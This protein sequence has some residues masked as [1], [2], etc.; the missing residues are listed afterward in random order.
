MDRSLWIA[1][2][3]MEGQATL[4]E[5]IANNLANV[6]TTAFKK[7]QV[8]FQDLFYQNVSQQGAEGTSNNVPVGVTLGTGSRVSSI[9]KDF[10]SGTFAES[11]NEL[12]LAING[13]G[14]FE[15]NLPDGSKAYTRDGNFHRDKDGKMVNENG[16]ELS[17][18]IT[19][20]K[21]ATLVTITTDGSVNVTVNNETSLAGTIQIS[22]F[23][24]NE[25]LQPI[26]D[27]MYVAT[28]AS[29]DVT[30]GTADQNGNGRIR[31]KYLESSNVDVVK[32][33]V[34]MIAAQRAYEVISKSIKTSDEMLRTATNLK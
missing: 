12:S 6:N 22:R 20:N 30:K 11:S 21:E 29:G 23:A 17:D 9:T 33:M 8:H 4:T 16:Y 3:G 34:N 18:G 26:G 25:G 15:V 7:G 13:D 32:E 1:A 2:T 27:N 31:Q 28:D 14:F 10:S 24:N 19:I 5:N